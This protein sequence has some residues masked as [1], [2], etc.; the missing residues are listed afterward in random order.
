MLSEI[1]KIGRRKSA[2]SQLGVMTAR[3]EIRLDILT[4]FQENNK[5]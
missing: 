1:F 3:Q 4:V 5:N 2:A